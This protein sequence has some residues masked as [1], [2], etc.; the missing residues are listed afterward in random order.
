MKNITGFEDACRTAIKPKQNALTLYQASA[1]I[2]TLQMPKVKG[3]SYLFHRNTF[4]QI[5]RLIDI[6]TPPNR[7]VIG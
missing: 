6:T 2:F 7:H 4:G 3:L 1:D 5:A